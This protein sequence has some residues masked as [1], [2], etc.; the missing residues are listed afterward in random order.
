MADDALIKFQSAGLEANYCF[1]TFQRLALDIAASLSGFLPGDF[2]A[3]IDSENEPSA[4]DRDKI[5]H[6][7]LPGGAPTGKFFKYYSGKWVTPNPV[8]PVSQSRLWFEGSESDAWGYDGGDGT[9][10]GTNVPTL[11]TGA[12]W[13][14][15]H[16]YDFRFALAAGTSPKPT[17]VSIGDVGGE[18]DHLLGITEIPAHTHAMTW[19]QNDT[20]GGNQQNTLYNGTDT[21]GI[22]DGIKKDTSSVGGGLAHNNLPPYRVGYWIKRT[23]RVYYVA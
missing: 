6:K 22:K 7:L 3:F 1:T 4:S 18:E 23:A 2:S 15:D 20:A 5:W 21:G 17:T 12:M 11:T 16:A 10:P 19:D 13:E 8:E 9:N 14:V